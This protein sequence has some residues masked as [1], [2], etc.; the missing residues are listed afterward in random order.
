[1]DLLKKL[2]VYLIVVNKNFKIQ[3]CPIAHEPVVAHGYLHL[4]AALKVLGN[5]ARPYLKLFLRFCQTKNFGKVDQNFVLK[6][7]VLL[8]C[9]DPGVSFLENY[10]FLS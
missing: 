10:L 2:L 3:L 7:F 5:A 6:F 4:V 8:I 9:I 1:M